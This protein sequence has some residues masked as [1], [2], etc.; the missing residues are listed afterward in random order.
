MCYNIDTKFFE[1]SM[2]KK[3]TRTVALATDYENDIINSDVP[4]SEYP[5][6]QLNRD[7]YLCLNGKWDFKII[8]DNAVFYNGMITLPFCPES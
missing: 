7:S 3:N 1:V 8:R 2:S 6:P 4:F 5:R